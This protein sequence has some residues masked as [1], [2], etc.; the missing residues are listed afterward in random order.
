MISPCTI[1]KDLSC[2]SWTIDLSCMLR[3][4]IIYS[5]IAT[6]MVC[7]VMFILLKIMK[8]HG[9]DEGGVLK[10]RNSRVK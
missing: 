9:K 5:L 4:S 7:L 2:E 10:V 3:T 6:A 1:C 8:K